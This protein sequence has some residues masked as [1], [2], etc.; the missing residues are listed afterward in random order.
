MPA[1]VDTPSLTLPCAGQRTAP[2]P[3]GRQLLDAQQPSEPTMNER[4]LLGSGKGGLNVHLWVVAAKG[5]AAALD[6]IVAVQTSLSSSKCRPFVDHGKWQ[7]K[8]A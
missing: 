5:R 2:L 3:T 4:P 7:S 8:F 1:F 6:P